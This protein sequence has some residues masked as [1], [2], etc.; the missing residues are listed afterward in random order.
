ML[1]SQ[2]IMLKIKNGIIAIIS[3]LAGNLFYDRE[4]ASL[5]H[6]I[7]VS[8]HF[9]LASSLF[10]IICSFRKKIEGYPVQSNCQSEAKSA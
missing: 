9:S 4:F 10:F 3:S 7:V 6:R 2:V 8:W 5:L 1:F